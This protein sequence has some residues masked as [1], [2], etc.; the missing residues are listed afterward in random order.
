MFELALIYNLHLLLLTEWEEWK[1]FWR[2][3]FRKE[4]PRWV[5]QRGI[6][7]E[8]KICL[9]SSFEEKS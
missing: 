6:I 9:L 2:A 5:Y 8:G 7:M 3:T 4:K 1:E